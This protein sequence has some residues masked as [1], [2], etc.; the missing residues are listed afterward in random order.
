MHTSQATIPG[1]DVLC[2]FANSLLNVKQ[3]PIS[4][5]VV[6]KSLDELQGF[7]AQ[8]Q[9]KHNKKQNIKMNNFVTFHFFLYFTQVFLLYTSIGH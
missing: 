2:R 7:R 5:K 6:T 1:I 3:S 9:L 4:V 8:V